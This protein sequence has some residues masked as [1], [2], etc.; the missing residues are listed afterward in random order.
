MP[1]AGHGPSQAQAEPELSRR[2]RILAAIIQANAQLADPKELDRS[3]ERALGEIG[4]AADADRIFIAPLDFASPAQADGPAITGYTWNHPE[5]LAAQAPPLPLAQICAW[6]EINLQ[7]RRGDF[8]FGRRTA[9]PAT[10]L[11][12]LEAMGARS[13][14]L[15]PLS[16]DAQ[17]PGVAGFAAC[18][19]ERCWTDGEK[20]L[21]KIALNMIGGTLGR[22]RVETALRHRTEDLIAA[23]EQLAKAAR[24]KDEFLASMSH[25]L[26]TPLNAI[27]G[28]SESLLEKAFGPLNDNQ[29]RYLG[30]IEES[31]RHLL[32]LINDILDLSK[33]EAGKL[34]PN[35]QPTDLEEVCAASLRLVR[36]QALKK[37]L[38]VFTRFS[39]PGATFKT[40]E[41]LLKQMLVNLLTNAVKFTPPDGE[42]GLETRVDETKNLI[43]FVVWDTGIGIAQE[44][45]DQLFQPFVQL[46]SSLS[47]QFAGTGL[48]LSLVRR[49]ALILDGEVTVESELNR[50][51][52]FIIRLP[53]HPEPR[54]GSRP[55]TLPV[56]APPA[57]PKALAAPTFRLSSDRP[58]ILLAEDNP[59]NITMMKGYLEQKGFRLLIAMNGQEAI[60]AVQLTTPALILM[61]IQMPGMDG[62]EATRRIKGNPAFQHIPIIALTALAMPGDRQRCLAA[63]ADDYF[64]KPSRLAVLL[65]VIHKQLD[66][67]EGLHSPPPPDQLP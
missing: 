6:P 35:L 34:T 25:E 41:R 8:V 17:L 42:I 32:M 26:R 22:H 31:G 48:G 30:R 29:T 39:P 14:L 12:V 45:L 46:D 38:Q 15:L 52:H 40:D 9:A 18:R 23:N 24:L 64:A 53:W 65:E 10:A 43:Q 60:H 61:D 67:A 16:L 50:G 4:L 55:D 19:T 21:L 49:M 20:T 27:L 58:L 28:L 59:V 47:R 63:G 7:L 37:H 56:D 13:F 11:K 66:Q 62:L 2:N 57:P 33:I 3:I 44:N 1:T 51:S 36:E 54:P 5:I